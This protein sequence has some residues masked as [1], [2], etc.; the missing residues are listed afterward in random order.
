[1]A[2]TI[3]VADNGDGSGAV[4]TVAGSQ[5]GSANVV[6]VSRFQGS[7]AERPFQSAGTRSGD[8]TV[9][10]GGEIGCYLAT[11]ISTS[12]G[13]AA[14]SEPI[15]FCVT[16]GTL[17]LYERVLE[18]VREFVLALALPGVASDPAKHRVCKIGAKLQELL[19]TGEEAVYYIPAAESF[20]YSDNAYATVS[21]PVNVVLISKSGSTLRGGLRE[22]LLAREDCHLSFDASPLPDVPEIHT[23]DVQPGAV[24]DPGNWAQGYDVS[25]MTFIAKSEQVDGILG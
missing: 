17:S 15:A 1:M 6:W 4:F 21:L 18:A 3:T 20:E 24:I 8:G 23:V 5:P 9:A 25:V 7:N 16:D 19:R 2:L 12:A 10:W 14:A 11:V 13:A 22:L